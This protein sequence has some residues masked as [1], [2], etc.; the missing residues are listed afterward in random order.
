M[1]DFKFQQADSEVSHS[2]RF[3]LERLA[4]TN[5]NVANLRRPQP[6]QKRERSSRRK[7]CAKKS[8]N[9]RQDS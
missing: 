9:W 3:C 2:H 8:S 5:E 4:L 6:L 1:L 7:E